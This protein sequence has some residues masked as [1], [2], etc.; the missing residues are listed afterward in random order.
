MKII[1]SSA[2]KLK[3]IPQLKIIIILIFLLNCN[4]NAKQ[5]NLNQSKDTITVSVVGD[6][7]CHSVQFNYARVEKDSFD[8][9]PVYR[10]VKKYFDES[11]FLFGN[12]ETVTAGNKKKYSGYPFFNAPDEFI[13]ALSNAGF[14]LLSTANNHAL[15]QGEYGIRR[16]IAQLNKNG[17]SYNGTFISQADRDS[18][19]IF[20]IK[21]IRIAFL[22]Y[23]YGTNGIPIPNGNSYLINLIDFAKI[24]NDIK[25]AKKNNADLVLVHYHFGE[26]YKR[27]PI[28]YQKNVVDSTI[29]Y[30]A[31]IIIGGHPHVIEPAAFYKSNSSDIDSVFVEYSMGNFISNQR[32]RY[33]DAG[34]ILNLEIVKDEQKDSIYISE[35]NYIPTW[36]FKGETTNGREYIILPSEI[37]FSYFIPDYLTSKD[38][39]LMKESF[40]DTKSILSKYSHRIKLKNISKQRIPFFYN[41]VDIIH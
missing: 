2:L 34:L 33:S 10:E 5:L 1:Y 39:D 12:L 16:T 35:V 19:R 21:G 37:A 4:F 27:E 24:R 29:K 13:T 23:T 11:D 3:F 18:I 20:D 9:N 14:D 28:N 25:S 15:D 40:N 41:S 38:I 8:F 26:E 7:M 6:L 30:G 31:D 32:W 36:V 17:I 22:A